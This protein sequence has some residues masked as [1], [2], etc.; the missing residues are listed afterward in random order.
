MAADDG[1]AYWTPQEAAAVWGAHEAAVAA[2][3]AEARARVRP[4][5]DEREA[6]QRAI[7]A[8]VRER[9]RKVYG[10]WAL[11][12][13]VAAASPPDAFYTGGE[14]IEFYSPDPVADLVELCD[15][16]HAA[17]HR[18]VQAREA[19]HSTTF[20]LSVE[21]HR[22]CD[23]THVPERAYERI[24]ATRM[25]CGA[26]AVDPAFLLLDQLRILTEPLTS[27][28]RLPR[29]LPRMALLVRLF[30]GALSAAPDPEALR[31]ALRAPPEAR[32]DARWLTG[33]RAAREWLASASGHSAAWG[34]TAAAALLRAAPGAPEGLLPAGQGED[35][36]A[37]AVHA[38]TCDL[39]EAAAGLEAAIMRAVPDA[40]A[41]RFAPL[42]DLLGPRVEWGVL[43]RTRNGNEAWRAFAV[44][45]GS[46]GRVVQLAP[47]M[48]G[49]CA[50]ASFPLTML[51]LLAGRFKERLGGGGGGRLEADSPLVAALCAARR[52]AG[53]GSAADPQSP[54]A[55]LVVQPDLLLGTTETAMAAHMR[56][57]DAR[58]AL[59]GGGQA[60]FSYDPSRV[61]G[62]GRP[63]W[64]Y[65]CA[66]RLGEPAQAPTA[67]AAAA[68]CREG[69]GRGGGRRRSPRQQAQE[70][71]GAPR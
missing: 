16:L 50:C 20:T 57:A 31:R 65:L 34:P 40:A 22:F 56:D 23:A 36:G 27:Y 55:D 52:R 9:G 2:A 37:A 69:R 3:E 54:F 66:G 59:F 14:D 17:G 49:A 35:E 68:A 46:A 10:G 63:H 42:L 11:N 64:R 39:P 18:Y 71:E 24:P 21:F 43:V 15:R 58:R 33:A 38:V 19:S 13:H 6:I 48:T 30:P 8:F 41:R 5:A 28:W 26:V 7:L 67:A 12:A 25:A 1:A 45:V 29:T 44:L 61:K 53:P 32:A 60:W 62:S 4:T 51:S 70:V 47:G